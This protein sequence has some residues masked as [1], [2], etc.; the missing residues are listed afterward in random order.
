MNRSLL[1]VCLVSV[2]GVVHAQSAPPSAALATRVK[3]MAEVP[4]TSSAVYSP[5]GKRI[6]FLSNRTGTPQ[7]WTVAAAGGEPKQM[8]YFPSDQI[9]WFDWSNDGKQ[10]ACSRGRMLNDI[11][12]ITESKP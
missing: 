6:A 11:V 1:A 8:T 10:L 9:F 12:L 7:V 5:D 2:L 4:S 3:A